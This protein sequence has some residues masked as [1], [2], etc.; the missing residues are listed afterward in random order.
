MKKIFLATIFLLSTSLF[1]GCEHEFYY[2]PIPDSYETTTGPY[3]VGDFYNEN[4]YAGVVFEVD[5]S[6]EH[7]KIVSL[8]QSAKINWAT[9]GN[10]DIRI[11][12][13]SSDDG[14]YNQAKVAQIKNWRTRF[15]AFAWCANLGDGWYLP[16]KDELYTFLGNRSVY[17][18]VNLKLF[19]IEAAKLSEG[20]NVFY[21]SSTEYSGVEAYAYSVDEGSDANYKHRYDSSYQCFIRAVYA[22]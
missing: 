8:Y 4:G 15:P 3:A 17:N 14:S 13:S 1:G 11:G 19:Q 18:A 2:G 12:A 21:W 9:Y 22:F 10:D 16:A 5:A 20:Y 6:G 7:G